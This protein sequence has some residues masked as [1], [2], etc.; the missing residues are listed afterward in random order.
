MISDK[1]ELVK[2]VLTAILISLVVFLPVSMIIR[3]SGRMWIKNG[4]EG[5]N[6][7][8][9]LPELWEA[10]FMFMALG[11]FFTMCYMIVMK[12]L[13]GVHYEI[14]EYAMVFSGTL[15]SNTAS[16]FIIWVKQKYAK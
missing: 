9:D 16:A 12:T 3:R 4:I 5:D 1:S 8:L 15:G 13:Y 7:R 2:L 14:F 11:C 10:L 6:Q